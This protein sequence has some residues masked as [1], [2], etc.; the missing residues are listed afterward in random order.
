MPLTATGYTALRA[1]DFIDT[2]RTAYETELTALGLP[3][4][5]DWERDVVLGIL[6]A[7]M[8]VQLGNLSEATQALYDAFDPNNAVGVQLDSLSAIVGVTRLPASASSATVTLTGTPGTII[9]AGSQVRGGSGDYTSAVWETADPF[10]IGGGGTVSGEVFAVLDGPTTATSATITEIVTPIAGWTAVTNPAAAAVGNAQETDA[11]LR[12]RRAESLQISAGRSIA[13]LRASLLTLDGVLGVLVIDNPT[14][15]TVTTGS[16]V[17]APHSVSVV[18]YPNTLTSTQAE[19]VAQ[20]IYD[21]LSAGIESNGTDEVFDVQGTDGSVKVIR[22][23][24]AGST[25]VNVVAT[26]VLDTGYVLADVQTAVEEAIEAY[27]DALVVGQSARRLELFGAIDDITGIVGLTLTM[28][29]LSTDITPLINNK[30][31]LG[32]NTVS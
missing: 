22:F 18:V 9:T 29:G 1:A 10:T 21:Q 4:D 6:T 8:G 13:A 23:D 2:I 19:A 17:L 16:L 3:S 28:N 20:A 11:E 25:T 27:F 30:L 24:Y 15:A 5:V 12:V 14:D 7:I 26:L 32:T 31:V